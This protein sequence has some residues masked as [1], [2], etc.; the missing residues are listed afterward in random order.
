MAR[1]FISSL[2]RGKANKAVLTAHSDAEGSSIE[3]KAV[4]FAGGKDKAAVDLKGSAVSHGAESEAKAAGTLVIE[5][6]GRKFKVIDKAEAKGKE[7]SVSID[8]SEKEAVP[9]EAAMP[10]VAEADPQDIDMTI[11]VAHSDWAL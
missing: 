5:T 3:G 8:L 1:V 9:V 10:V 6:G 4:V 11:S 7:A 2:G